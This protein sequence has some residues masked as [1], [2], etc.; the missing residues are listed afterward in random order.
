MKYD[1]AIIGAGVMGTAIAYHASKKGNIVIGTGFSGH[2]FKFAPLM[3][4]ILANFAIEG[5]TEYDISRF[6]LHR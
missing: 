5:G 3:G 4:K 2:G 1:V 6:H